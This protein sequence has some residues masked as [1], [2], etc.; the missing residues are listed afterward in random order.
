MPIYD[1]LADRYDLLWPRV[2]D[3]SF[4]VELAEVALGSVLELGCGTGRTA[5]TVAATGRRVIGIDLSEPMLAKAERRRVEAGIPESSLQFICGSMT[6]FR[7]DERFSLIIAP[8]SA[9]WELPNAG[10]REATFRQCLAHL[11]PDGILA[12]DCS[13]KGEGAHAYWG[14]VR[15]PHVLRFVGDVTDSHTASPAHF[16][17]SEYESADGRRLT[18]FVDTTGRSDSLDRWTLSWTRQYAHPEEVQS[19]LRAAGFTRIEVFGGFGR[20]PLY[21]P[22]LAG[23]GRQVFVARP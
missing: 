20:Q 16:F 17:D 18:L 13:F 8:F 12:F 19:E 2:E 1:A 22:E 15:R 14:T 23:R 4:Y 9:L 6:D 7:L 21:A 11:A 3:L 5:C 10:E